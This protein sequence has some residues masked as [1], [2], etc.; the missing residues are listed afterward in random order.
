MGRV[1]SG[2]VV[3]GVTAG[4]MALRRV[5]RAVAPGPAHG[6]LSRERWLVVTVALPLEEVAPQGRWPEP[7][8]ALGDRVEVRVRPAPG[9]KGTELAAR[10]REATPGGLP[11]AAARWTGEDPQQ[12]LRSALRRSKQLLEVGEVLE[13]EPAPHGH[14]TATPGGALLEKVTRLAGREGRL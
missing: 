2:L 11:G 7:L 10:L 6:G 8:A 14:R 13:V 4:G 9:D 1:G 12:E 3:A 5:L